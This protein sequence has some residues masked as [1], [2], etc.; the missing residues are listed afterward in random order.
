MYWSIY[1]FNILC[2]FPYFSM[3]A[4]FICSEINTHF[5][6]Y[7][8]IYKYYYIKV[9]LQSQPQ[10][11]FFVC[12][13]VYICIIGYVIWNNYNVKTNKKNWFDFLFFYSFS[14]RNTRNMTIS[15]ISQLQKNSYLIISHNKIIRAIQ[16]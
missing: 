11:L 14:N 1:Y 10:L 3:H 9:S 8:Y 13:T 5:H 4:L 12:L 15:V 2:V 16:D 6:I 7:V